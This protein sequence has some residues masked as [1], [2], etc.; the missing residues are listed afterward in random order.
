MN[1][2][3]PGIFTVFVLL[4][5]L[6]TNVLFLVE[7]EKNGSLYCVEISSTYYNNGTN[8]WS[9]TKEDR[10]IILFPNNT[11]QTI[12]LVNHSH[13]LESSTFDEEEN[14]ITILKLPKKEIEPGENLTVTIK[15][16]AFSRTRSFQ[17]IIEIDSGTL[18]EIPEELKRKYSEKNDSWLVGDEEL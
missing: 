14:P 5:M 1:S 18:E 11:W 7:N 10:T 8:V 13:P 4:L 6:P 15:F 17:N 9:L 2:K 3:I 16:D 12:T